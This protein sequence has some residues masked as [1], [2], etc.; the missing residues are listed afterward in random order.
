MSLTKE[1]RDLFYLKRK[2]WQEAQEHA[3]SL[4]A[5]MDEIAKEPID[6]GRICHLVFCCHRLSKDCRCTYD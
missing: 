1:Q 5:E 2:Q 3:N 6:G 4:L